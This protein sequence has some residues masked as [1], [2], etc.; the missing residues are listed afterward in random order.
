MKFEKQDFL[1]QQVRLDDNK[2]VECHFEN[3]IM[4]YGGG[5]PPAIVGCSFSGVVLSFTDAAA[6]TLQFMSALYHVGGEGGRHIVEQ[7]FETIRHAEGREQRY[8]H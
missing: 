2:F 1:K 3:C 6:N 5:P 4:T 8:I 7:T